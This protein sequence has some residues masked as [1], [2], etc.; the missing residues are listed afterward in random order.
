MDVGYLRVL[1]GRA[2]K[3]LRTSSTH[4]EPSEEHSKPP[5]SENK[6]SGK[7]EQGKTYSYLF[8]VLLNDGDGNHLINQAW[9]PFRRVALA[10]LLYVNNKQLP[11]IISISI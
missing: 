3:N 9:I 10:P 2:T 6:L 8:T 11:S 7:A 4:K 5:C 1:T